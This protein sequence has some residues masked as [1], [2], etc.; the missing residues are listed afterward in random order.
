MGQKS[1]K[2]RDQNQLLDQHYLT[3]LYTLTLDIVLN[4]NFNT[5]VCVFAY[6]LE[7]IIDI[8]KN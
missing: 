3:I 7:I 6:C 8:Q 2:S 5:F 1:S 4:G